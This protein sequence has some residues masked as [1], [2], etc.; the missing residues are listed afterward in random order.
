MSVRAGSGG[1]VS[2]DVVRFGEAFDADGG[3]IV[4][5]FIAPDLL[6][7]VAGALE[8]NGVEADQLRIEVAEAVSAFATVGL[9][10]GITPGLEPAGQ[11][12][13]IVLMSQLPKLFGFSTDAD[14]FI[15]S[16]AKSN[17]ALISAVSSASSKAS[18]QTTGILCRILFMASLRVSS[19]SDFLT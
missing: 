16:A 1:Q 11:I 7:R 8:R 2:G 13:V 4:E 15:D 10:T 9:S 19:R 5:G 14:G 12:A 17:F 6:A 18:R 3:L